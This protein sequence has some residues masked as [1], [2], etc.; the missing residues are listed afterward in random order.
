[1]II[2]ISWNLLFSTF[3]LVIILNLFI[4][5]HLH[6][7]TCFIYCTEPGKIMELCKYLCIIHLYFPIWDFYS[8]Q[9]S[10]YI[11]SSVCIRKYCWRLEYRSWQNGWRPASK[12]INMKRVMHC[13]RNWI[14]KRNM[15]LLLFTLEFIISVE[16]LWILWIH[17]VK[18]KSIWQLWPVC[19]DCRLPG[20]IGN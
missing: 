15:H 14:V 12:K 2:H 17:R 11:S 10:M 9:F 4:C 3:F 13:V 18:C 5:V 1:M 16:N 20:C 8:N 19:W 7:F 6:F